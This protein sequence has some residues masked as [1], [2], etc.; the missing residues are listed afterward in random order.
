MSTALLGV[1]IGTTNLKTVA[2]APDGRQ[3]AKASTPTPTNYP[4]PDWAEFDQSALWDALAGTIREAV[5][6][7]PDGTKPSAIAFTGMAEAGLPL[8]KD[9]RPLYAAITWFDR[10]VL[11]QMEEWKARVGEA[12]TARITG[13]PVA[14]AAGVLR[15]LWLRDNE[16]ELFARTRTWLNLPDYAAYW[17]CGEK[18]T[19]H[20]LA[21]RMMVFD[22]G[23][24]RWSPELLDQCDLDESMFGELAPSAVQIG[25]VHEEA[26]NLTGLPKGL[27]VCTGGHDHLCA[28]VGLGVTNADDLFDSIGTAEAIIA[29]LPGRNDDPAI[30]ES[31][32]AQGMHVLPDRYYA[33][34]GNTFGGGSIDWTRKLLLGALPEDERSFETLI[35]L[36]SQVPA[37]SGGAV[38]LPHLRRAN[39]PILDPASRGAFVGLSS[40]CGPGHF[41]R[42]VFEGLAF[43][44]QR[45]QDAVC[46]NFSLSSTRLVATGGGTRNRL[47]M[48]IKSDVSGLP[49]IVPDVEESTCLGAALAAG[50]GSGV[51]SDYDDASAQV[52]LS[53]TVIEPD[54]PTHELYRDRYEKVFVKL[55]DSLKAVNHEISNWI[56]TETNNE[57]GI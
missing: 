19:E 35:D 13:L 54:G 51:F 33:I 24:K 3:L 39:P 15:L 14:P 52:T 38:F 20:S 8:D 48:Q 7:L 4:R 26:A 49:I 12:A 44:F 10:R 50:V 56:T 36:A 45:I 37:G 46:D 27:P 43:E 41:A 5:D 6:K 23:T 57:P 32:I 9:D 17:L 42:A 11:P 21:S 34:S 25:A 16:P 2:F 47:F 30:A 40:D 18:V 29:A 28:A 53:E 22:L 1:D 31:G 55:Y